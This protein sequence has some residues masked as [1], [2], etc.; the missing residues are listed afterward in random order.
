VSIQLNLFLDL[1]FFFLIRIHLGYF[2][3]KS[4]S[5][6]RG[7]GVF[8]GSSYNWEHARITTHGVYRLRSKNIPLS[9]THHSPLQTATLIDAQ[10]TEPNDMLRVIQGLSIHVVYSNS[11]RVISP[12]RSGPK[13]DD[14]ICQASSIAV[15]HVWHA[16]G[17]IIIANHDPRS[18]ADLRSC[19]Q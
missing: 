5:T 2:T 4:H 1:Q 6:Y 3:L 15:E 18:S 17:W 10:Y 12:L 16:N 9:V 13:L 7:G 8:I 19:S 11:Q 14:G